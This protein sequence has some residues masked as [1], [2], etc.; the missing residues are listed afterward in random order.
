MHGS[1]APSHQRGKGGSDR[2]AEKAIPFDEGTV[3]RNRHTWPVE[4]L[5]VD[6][7]RIGG[8]TGDVVD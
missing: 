7:R 6:I 8:G 4:I 2:D 3:M 1:P 5:H